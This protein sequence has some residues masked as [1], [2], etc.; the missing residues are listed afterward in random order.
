MRSVCCSLLYA[1]LRRISHLV[2]LEVKDLY[3]Y[4]IIHQR[5]L[6]VVSELSVIMLYDSNTSLDKALLLCMLVVLL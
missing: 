2:S 3:W 1:D 6:H 5:L 4:V